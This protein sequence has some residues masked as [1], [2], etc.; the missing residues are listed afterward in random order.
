MFLPVTFGKTRN[1]IPRTAVSWKTN[2]CL[3]WTEAPD[4]SIM[5]HKYPH[6]CTTGSLLQL[7]LRWIIALSSLGLQ[8]GENPSASSLFK[9]RNTNLQPHFHFCT[10]GQ[11]SRRGLTSRVVKILYLLINPGHQ[12]MLSSSSDTEPKSTIPGKS[13]K[14]SQGAAWGFGFSHRELN[15]VL[16]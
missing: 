12:G 6:L 3:A 15:P 16:G 10:C 8:Q 14:A 5:D 9:E 13:F 7:A 1:W 11:D 2:I 4:P